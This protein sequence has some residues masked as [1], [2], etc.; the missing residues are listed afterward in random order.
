[1]PDS[2]TH[3]RE[4]NQAQT[5]IIKRHIDEHKWFAHIADE[6]E[7]KLDFILK[8]GWAMRE[9][10][11]NYICGERSGCITAY[12]LFHRWPNSNNPIDQDILEVAMK[13]IVTRHL[14]EYMGFEHIADPDVA[15]K[16]FVAK[17][18]WIIQELI[19]GFACEHRFECSE[20]IRFLQENKKLEPET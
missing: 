7:G 2:C 4:L 10:F 15:I 6:E 13:E 19:C 5:T 9:V 1:M 11:C 16:D 3:L 14:D 8:F 17:F 18:G 20:A 12:K